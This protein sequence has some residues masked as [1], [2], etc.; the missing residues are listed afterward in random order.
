MLAEARGAA[1]Y[2]V[3]F[4]YR[5]GEHELGQRIRTWKAEQR[6]AGRPVETAFAKPATR[7]LLVE[8]GNEKL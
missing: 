5:D 7:S 3:H 6:A 4:T 2:T 1:P 8:L